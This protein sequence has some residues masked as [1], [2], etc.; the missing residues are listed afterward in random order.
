MTEAGTLPR[1]QGVGGWCW[2]Q[3]QFQECQGLISAHES[4]TRSSKKANKDSSQSLRGSAALLIP[5]LHTS[6]LQNYERINFWCFKWLGLCMLLICYS[7]P[8]KL[9]QY[10]SLVAVRCWLGPELLEGSIG[11][12]V[13]EGSSLQWQ[14]LTWVDRNCWGLTGS[15]VILSLHL[16]PT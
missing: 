16:L 5:S 12:K 1:G 9:V 6:C 14:V 7:S 13:Q 8:Q 11:L 10:L 2:T 4:P 15:P 3:L